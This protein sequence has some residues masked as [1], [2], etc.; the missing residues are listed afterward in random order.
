[1]IQSDKKQNK[2][3]AET[4][5]KLDLLEVELIFFRTSFVAT[6]RMHTRRLIKGM[7]FCTFAPDEW[8]H[9]EDS[10]GSATLIV[11]LQS[12]IYVFFNL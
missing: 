9:M 10:K 11:D 3:I 12:E 6:T 4:T 2:L 1:M 7:N 5:I 8:K